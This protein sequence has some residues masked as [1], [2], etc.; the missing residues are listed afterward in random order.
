MIIGDYLYIEPYVY[1]LV[2]NKAAILYN[3]L[4]GKSLEYLA[5]TAMFGLIKRLNKNKNLYVLKLKLQERNNVDIMNFIEKIR[6][7]YMGDIIKSAIVLNKPI[8]IKPIFNIQKDLKILKFSEDITVGT[9]I[10]QNVTNI[11]IYINSN[12]EQECEYCLSAYKQF[13]NCTKSK[14]PN[15]ELNISG[16]KKNLNNLISSNIQ[17]VNIL[18]GNILLYKD[19]KEL[20]V[21]LNKYEFNT[22]FHINYKNLAKINMEYLKLLSNPKFFVNVLFDYPINENT[23]FS[24]YTWFKD[25]Q[26]N[27][28]YSFVIENIEQFYKVEQIISNLSLTNYLILP[29]YNKKNMSFFKRNIFSTKKDILDSKTSL[30]KIYIR[31]VL[32]ENYFGKLIIMNDGSVLS[33]LNEKP[34]INIKLKNLHEAAYKGMKDSKNWRKI[35]S[36][37]EPCKTCL[38][39]FI[40]PPISNYEYALGKYNLCNVIK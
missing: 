36:N 40:C 19:F 31:Q 15:I 16:I 21:L 10:M 34:V 17:K 28:I 23:L 26:I 33:N 1:I 38:Y 2:N 13:H 9:R 32:N 3:T 18:G 7:N 35:R 4:N 22:E 14:A 29:Y 37:V 5:S 30:E 24:I 27:L 11:S 6:L 8:Q 12:C 20:L 25:S 39:K